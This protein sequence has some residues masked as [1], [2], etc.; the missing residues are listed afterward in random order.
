M[1]LGGGLAALGD[2]GWGGCS[3][4][5]T[6]CTRILGCWKEEVN[7][8]LWANGKPRRFRKKL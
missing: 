4:G 7:I 1:D 6:I 3:V 5:F 8:V 2:F